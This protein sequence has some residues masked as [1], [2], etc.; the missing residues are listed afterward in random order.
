[1]YTLF[2]YSFQGRA[3][4]KE[5]WMFQLYFWLILIV[6]GGIAVGVAEAGMQTFGQ[7]MLGITGLF[8]VI[9]LW[10]SITIAVRRLHDTG[11][12]GLWIFILAIPAIG[13]LIFLALMC[14]D[15][16]PYPNDYGDD[17]KGRNFKLAQQQPQ[18]QPTIVIN[19][20]SQVDSNN[21]TNVVPDTSAEK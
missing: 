5:F 1:M 7:I 4:R 14:I 2:N 3:R 11:R 6:L 19:N 8:Y 17:P 13:P 18:A 12:S 20:Q 16:Q 21:T 9:V 10:P 15:G